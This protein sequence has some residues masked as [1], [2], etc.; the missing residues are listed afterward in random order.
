EHVHAQAGRSDRELARRRCERPGA[1]PSRRTRGPDPPGQAQGHLHPARRHR[2]LRDHP[3]RG[4]GARDRPQGG[5]AG[6][7]DVLPVPERPAHVQLQAHARAAP[8]KAGRARRAAHAA[9]E[10][11]GPEHPRQAEDLPRRPPPAQRAAAEGAE[12]RVV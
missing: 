7:S 11:D 5:R 4:Q 2:R 3:E 10:Q 8:G 12:V 9:Q 1:R 6:V